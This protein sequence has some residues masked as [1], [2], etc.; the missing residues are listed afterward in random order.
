VDAI[1]IRR[2][3]VAASWR[4]RGVAGRLMTACLRVV[5][6]GTPVWL[7][8]FTYNAR[9]IAFYTKYGFRVVGDTTFLM[10][11][12]PQRDHIMQWTGAVFSDSSVAEASDRLVAGD[13]AR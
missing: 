12:D 11:D 1:E 6:P 9:A 8:V 3:Y 4:G 2:F 7:G 13:P 10:G 5:P